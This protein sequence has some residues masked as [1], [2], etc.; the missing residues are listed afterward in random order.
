MSSSLHIHY[1]PSDGEILAWET[2]EVP[3]NADGCERL[4]VEDHAGGIDPKKQKIDVASL[5]LVD[6]TEEE[7]RSALVP[8]EHAVK[9][10]IFRE[11][12]H[13]DSFVLLDRPMDDELK[14]RWRSYRQTLR[15][16]SKLETPLAMI[17][18]WPTRPDGSDAV[19][20]LRDL[21]D[22]RS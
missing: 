2:S 10:A 18:A 21:V 14:T 6:K 7:N 4:V 17:E 1:R 12:Q 9:S 22:K 8:T 15:D 19:K 3:G 5:A 16:L 11:L 20:Q 13:T